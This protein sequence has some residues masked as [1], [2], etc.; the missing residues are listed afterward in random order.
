MSFK[1]DIHCHPHLKPYSRAHA[2]TPFVQSINPGHVSSLWYTTKPTYLQKS[3][4]NMLG[5]TLFPQ[6]DLSAAAKGNVQVMVVAMGCV[7]KGFVQFRGVLSLFEQLLVNLTTGFGKT[8]VNVLRGMQDYWSDFLKEMAF[9]QSGEGRP[10]KIG[11]RWMTYKLVKDFTSL[12]EIIEYNKQIPANNTAADP[13]TIAF[14]PSVEGMHIL[15]T[16]LG[17]SPDQNEVLAKLKILKSSPARP[18]F[19]SL[20]HHFFN[21][22]CGH[23]RSFKAPMIQALD[24]SEGMDS[25]FTELGKRVLAELL[26][27]SDGGPVFIDLKHMSIAARSYYIDLIRQD[28]YKGKVPIIISHG[29]CNGAKDYSAKGPTHRLPGNTFYDIPLSDVAAG[30]DRNGKLIDTNQI[31]FYDNEILEMIRTKGIMGIQLD[32]RRIAN[33]LTF[34]KLK[35]TAN[36]EYNEKFQYSLLVWNQVLYIAQ[37]A[38]GR[39]LPAWHHVALG[40][41]F[42]G[43]VDPL[44]RF[45]TLEEYGELEA[46]LLLHARNFVG[47]NVPH[48]MR[49]AIN[50]LTAEAIV[51]K[52]FSEN[53]WSFF[54]RWYS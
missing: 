6:A 52:L 15:N 54:E 29:V 43:I 16:G 41:D 33:N 18:W 49:H 36:T 47:I 53:A 28:P 46:F 19:V 10:V 23:S 1:I 7:E 38:D 22:L 27:D 24:Q 42:D 35:K 8:R 14:I 3:A 9:I 51:R 37:M 25:G 4:N 26:S 5:V 11:E 48:P 39:G 50:Q 30:Y 40:S 17:T 2:Y 32:E 31:N 21:Q 13:V 34:K 44:N 20:C 45:W 12:H